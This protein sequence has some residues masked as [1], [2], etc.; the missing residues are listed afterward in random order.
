MM[1]GSFYVEGSTKIFSSLV[2]SIPLISDLISCMTDRDGIAGAGLPASSLDSGTKP[3][4]GSES[5]RGGRK[6]Y[7]SFLN[8]PFHRS[9][10]IHVLVHNLIQISL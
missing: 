9:L 10:K 3:G 7:Q 6:K 2:M 5:S 4:R 8:F 1:F